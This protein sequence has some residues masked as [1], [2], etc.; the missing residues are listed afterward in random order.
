MYVPVWELLD[1]FLLNSGLKGHRS[2][3]LRG[4]V[5]FWGLLKSDYKL[6]WVKG[7]VGIPSFVNDVKGHVPRSRDN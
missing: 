4:N 2:S 3:L 5:V 6:T 1:I 7:A